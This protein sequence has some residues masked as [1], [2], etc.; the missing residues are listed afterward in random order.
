MKTASFLSRR[1]T[2]CPGGVFFLAAA[3]LFF[4]FP[5]TGR[6]AAWTLTGSMATSRMSPTVTLLPDGK[7]LVAGGSD[8]SASLRTCELYDPATGTWSLT[9]PMGTARTGHTATLLQNGKVLVA[10]GMDDSNNF[11][12]TCELYDYQTGTWSSTGD[13]HQTHMMQA[14]VLLPNDEGNGKVLLA[15]GINFTGTCMAGCELYDPVAGTWTVTGTMFS[16]RAYAAAVLLQ[17][18]KALIAGG[19]T[20]LSGGISDSV[21]LYDNGSWTSV[22]H[23][24]ANRMMPTATLLSGG[25]VLLAGGLTSSLSSVQN[26]ATA[27]CDLYDPSTGSVGALAATGAMGTARGAHTATT[28]ANG[29]VLVAGGVS[30]MKGSTASYSSAELYDPSKGTWGTTGSL[31]DARCMHGAVLLPVGKV[32]A[33]AGTAG[34]KNYLSSAELFSDTTPVVTPAISLLLQD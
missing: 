21:E 33:V 27:S 10:G 25:K 32:L 5:A 7:V 28:L 29:K 18:G 19:V 14:A 6:A 17:N 24:S 8:A 1:K 3:L 31:H 2:R 4:A 23:M 13:M 15:G 26:S 20:D 11:L 9:N 12:T 16:A 34:Q 22:G 30:D